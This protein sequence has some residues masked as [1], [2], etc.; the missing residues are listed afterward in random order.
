[1]DD[2]LLD[3]LIRER[4]QSLGDGVGFISLI[5]VFC[6]DALCTVRVAS[7]DGAMKITTS[8]GLHLTEAG[9]IFIASKIQDDLVPQR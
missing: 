2:K 4:V 8:D 7:G 1:M 3:T 5:D 9:S 6:Q